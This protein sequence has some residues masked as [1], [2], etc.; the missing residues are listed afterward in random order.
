[1]TGCHSDP[2]EVQLDFNEIENKSSA[3]IEDS[4][5]LKVAVSA[6][7]GPQE[8]LSSYA[9][10]LNYIGIKINRQI[11]FKQRRTYQE[12][13]EM[14]IDG[15]LDLAFIC[16]GAY[17]SAAESGLIQLL[18]VH[19]IDE[20]STYQSYLL[21]PS[22][23]QIESFNELMGKHFAY[24]DP[25]SFT[26]CAYPKHSI[27]RLGFSPND[28]FS[29]TTFTYGHDKAIQAVARGMVHG[30]CVDG[31]IF[32]FL[33]EKKP[34]KV[35]GVRVVLKSEPFGI[36]PVVVSS[37]IDSVLEELLRETLLSMH[38]DPEG[39]AILEELLI[40]GFTVS[41]DSLYN[42]IRKIRSELGEHQ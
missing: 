24:T 16:S 36:P 5:T 39:Q 21:V 23:S 20:K 30:A 13:N 40:D 22:N 26:G 41:H 18:V 34:F 25:L 29:Q 8:T 35:S 7:T 1:M 27:L 31:L 15:S 14:L 32:D 28:F 37:T 33:K 6:M 12:V 17:I 11:R 4:S 42:S 9:D 2:D 3:T 10:L 19:V 38:T